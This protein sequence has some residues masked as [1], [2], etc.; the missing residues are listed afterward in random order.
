MRIGPTFKDRADAGRLLATKL[1]ELMAVEPALVDPVVL[2][3]PRGGVPVAAEV[4]QRLGAPLDLLFARK[5]G[6][7]SHPELALGAVVDGDPPQLVLNE[8][9][10]AR[11]RLTDGQIEALKADALIEIARRRHRYLKGRDRVALSGRPVIVVDDGIATGA[12]VRA[13]LRGLKAQNPGPLVLAVPVAPAS[14]LRQFEQEVD[15][16]ICLVTPEPFYAIGAHYQR[17]DQ[18]S[19]AEVTTL[20]HATA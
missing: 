20:L 6:L 10:R 4:A 19:D 1:T 9:I 3:L 8:D 2:A 16:L 14:T 13:A 15:H 11:S 7:P 17:F 12:T 18:L 5:L